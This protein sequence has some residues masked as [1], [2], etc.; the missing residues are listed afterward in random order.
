MAE[1]IYLLGREEI[2]F[3]GYSVQKLWYHT[4]HCGDSITLA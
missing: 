2:K 4:L 3:G 1:K